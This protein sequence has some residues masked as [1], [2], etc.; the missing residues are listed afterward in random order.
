MTASSHTNKIPVLYLLLYQKLVERFGRKPIEFWAK[1]G[2]EVNRRMIYQVPHKYDYIIL[3]E[4]TKYKLIKKLSRDKYE[5][6]ID[7]YDNKTKE[8]NT[9]FLWD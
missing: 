7:D 5:L 4:L 6:V 1:D 3:K 8:L 9:Y 2:I